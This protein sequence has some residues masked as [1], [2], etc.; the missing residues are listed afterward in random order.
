M[1]L[2]VGGEPE[3]LGDVSGDVVMLNRLHILMVVSDGQG[4]VDVLT[5]LL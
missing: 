2:S 3:V 4:R 5:N 1:A